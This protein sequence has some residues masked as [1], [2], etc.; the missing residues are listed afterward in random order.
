MKPK[1]IVILILIVGI[2]AG[3]IG[4]LIAPTKTDVKSYDVERSYEQKEKI[5]LQL[6][7]DSAFTIASN[8]QKKRKLDSTS[9][10]NQI[11]K[12]DAHIEKLNNLINEISLK[13]ASARDLDS[14]RIALYGK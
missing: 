1:F 3:L 9:Y 2:S 14:I 6:L 4:Y 7:A 13:N 10:A 5:R 12:K 8:L 11:H